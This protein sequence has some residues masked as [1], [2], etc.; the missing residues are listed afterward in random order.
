M[1][2]WINEDFLSWSGFKM[3]LMDDVVFYMDGITQQ[4][5]LWDGFFDEHALMVI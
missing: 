3:D 4:F 2:L 1:D 5:G